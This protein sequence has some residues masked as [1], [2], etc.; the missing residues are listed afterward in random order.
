MRLIIKKRT[1]VKLFEALG[2][3]T[4]NT[5]DDSRL[6]RKINEIPELVEEVE[7]K[8]PKV[9]RLIEKILKASE[10]IL[11]EEKSKRPS[12]DVE[13]ETQEETQKE[14]EK[15]MSKKSEKS[16]KKKKAAKKTFANYRFIKKKK[17]CDAFGR[18]LGT[19]GALI[20]EH[21][22]KKG[23]SV[24]QLIEECKLPAARISFH[25]RSFVHE[26]FLKKDKD[27]KYILTG[28]TKA[29]KTK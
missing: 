11:K 23:K 26:G 8:N 1:V 13:E 6:M 4:A 3:K 2:F 17:G 22:D 21:L 9:K 7:V 10:V 29:N 18:R 27:N 25:M 14:K 19:Q 28:K 20:D 5:W 16:K 15:T 12:E 24:K